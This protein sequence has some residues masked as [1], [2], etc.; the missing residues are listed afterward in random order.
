MNRLTF[1][2]SLSFLFSTHFSF[3]ATWFVTPTG[4]GATDGTTW[5]NASDD[6]QVIINGATAGD[7]IWVAT[8]T[9]FPLYDESGNATPADNRM[10]T[11]VM[12][13]GVKIYGGFIGGETLVSQ[14]DYE[15]NV[16][17]LSGDLGTL[18]TRTDDAYHVMKNDN[19][20]LTNAAILDGFTITRGYANGA[21]PENKG[22]GIY[23][24]SVSPTIIN[25]TIYDNKTPTGGNTASGIFISASSPVITNCL[26][27]SNVAGAT[28]GA[29]LCNSVSAPVITNC[30]FTRNKAQFGVCVNITGGSDVTL[31]NCTLTGNLKSG[32]NDS[33]MIQMNASSTVTATNCSFINNTC[34]RNG[35]I[36]MALGTAIIT[37][38]LFANNTSLNTGAAIHYRNGANITVTN[39]TF[40]N[41]SSA[42]GGA[43][44][45]NG[46]GTLTLE[47][48]IFFGN[49]ATVSGNTLSVAT[50]VCNA[51]NTL[52]DETEVNSEVSNTGEVTNIFSSDPLFIDAVNDNFTLQSISP[53]LDVGNNTF[54]AEA[55]DLSGNT[56]AY[57][58]TIDL[59]AYEYQGCSIAP[60][61]YFRTKAAGNWED[62]SSW[63][64]SADGT[65]NWSNTCDSPDSQ[66]IGVEVKHDL[67]VNTNTTTAPQTKINIGVV[68]RVTNG[69]KLT[70]PF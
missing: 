61:Y 42:D 51:F 30:T 58:T 43:I 37:N 38:C 48:S 18:N 1:L 69:V 21:D 35:V 4:A 44:Y 6:L 41:N 13:E 39:S 50:G 46:T 33:P 55:L 68:L 12:K 34:G 29:M 8:G 62:A 7:Q 59:G 65:T 25:C 70:V 49:T 60:T 23:L 64:I 47:N 32:S 10:K 67:R 54:N 3:G 9:Y 15:T 63:E 16:T 20:G 24:T 28:G 11:F 17:T 27:D 2:V 56:R 52:F 45:S 53:A 19:N 14:R 66:A 31:E 5:A 36:Q 26:F 40:Y 57:N 22:S